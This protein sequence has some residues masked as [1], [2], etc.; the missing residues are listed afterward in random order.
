MAAFDVII[1]GAGTAGESIAKNVA[2][3]GRTVAL[4]EAGRV[5][6]ECPYVACMPSKS[7]LRSATVRHQATRS[8]ALGATAGPV[9]L[10]DPAAGY[11]RA[12]ARR[13]EV[14]HHRDDADAATGVERQGVTLLRGRGRVVG[15]GV[16]EVGG[17]RYGFTDLVIGTGSRPVHPPIEGLDTVPTWTSDEALSTDERPASLLVLGGGPIGCELAQVYARFGVEVTLV[18]SAPRLVAKEE[19]SISAV[20]AA[21]LRDDGIDLRLGAEVIRAETVGGRAR[22][23]LA[24]GAVLDGDR[25]LVVTGRMPNLDDLGLE[26]LGI[27]ADPK[28]L[29]TDESGRVPGQPHV[30]AAGDVTGAAPYT[31]AANYQARVIA[32]NLLGGSATM[33]TRA[34]PRAI[35][36]DPPVASVGLDAAAA[37]LQ[38]VEAVTASI[39]LAETAR[40]GSEG[41]ARGRLVLTADAARGVLVGA[42]AVG[43]GCDEWIGEA[44]L[45]IRAEIPLAVLT[46]V[47]HPFP[48][49]SEAYEPVLRDLA[50]QVAAANQPRQMGGTA[51]F[52]MIGL[53]RMGEALALQAVDRGL[54][55]VAHD[56]GKE[57]KPG[58]GILPA[59]SVASVV[60]QLPT[61]RVV[62]VSV[63]QGGPTEEVVQSLA[64]AME[65]GD[66]IV[67]GG[68][69]HWRDSV[70]RCGEL[71]QRGI[72][73][74]DCGTSGGV[75]GARHG[76]CF[77][78]GGT[79]EAFSLVEPILLALAT[80]D[81]VLHVGPTGSGHFVK[82]I[83]NMIE[84][85]MVQ[86]IG[87]GVELLDASDYELDFV[88]LFRNWSHGSVI[89]GWL[90]EL[91]A[92][93]FEEYGDLSH[94]E[95]CVE[96]TGEQVWGVQ[97][98]MEHQVPIPMLAQAVW[99]FYQS[100]DRTQEWEKAVSVLR[101]GYGGHPLST[102]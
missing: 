33:D 25:V 40:S 70:R 16:V 26:V 24:D 88:S 14:A 43:P 99:G 44:V 64:E 18:E 34:M 101:H 15:E 67:E 30:W 60:G 96:D 21:V 86:S 45:A 49:F 36:T 74:I 57:P 58:S 94:V 7:L 59:D 1:L 39:D 42:A 56:P 79:E 6:G 91:M 102:T 63:P 100:R 12:T 68:N 13:D 29:T 97:Y 72:H 89:R 75:S 78:V 8:V 53:G 82:L 23:R 93:G 5:G 22:L 90:V 98:A 41:E 85:G 17:A 54:E 46:D 62:F 3:A 50:Q 47:V 66:V 80:H 35:Y 55:V 10:D 81:G 73:F 77:M 95:P 51:R 20:L 38:G 11:A 83:H 2:Q 84:F 52:G 27:E 87:E 28:G 37:R 61:P 69:A 92:Q 31:H 9:A 71:A 32:A 76:A 19:A 4:V 65:P 48:T